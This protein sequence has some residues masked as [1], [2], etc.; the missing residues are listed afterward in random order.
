MAIQTTEG[1]YYTRNIHLATYLEMV[2]YPAEIQTE[3]EAF[4]TT[5]DKSGRCIFWHKADEALEN[6]V[7]NFYRHNSAVEPVTYAVTMRNLKQRMY[8]YVESV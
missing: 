3:E 7:D 6:I 2:G 8:E 4:K 1:K 5:A